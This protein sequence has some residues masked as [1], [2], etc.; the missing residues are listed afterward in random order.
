MIYISQRAWAMK[1]TD[2]VY[3]LISFFHFITN[4]CFLVA[5][6]GGLVCVGCCKGRVLE[7]GL[8]RV[9]S[10]SYYGGC[11]SIASEGN[12]VGSM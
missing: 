8:F 2:S 3:L 11:D 4:R 9:G 12:N 5:M 10:V 6:G 1:V 7:A